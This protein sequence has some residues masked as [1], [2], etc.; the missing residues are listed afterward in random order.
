VNARWRWGLILVALAAVA[1]LR[2]GSRDPGGTHEVVEPTRSVARDASRA[3]PD[4][5]NEIL[6]LRP[7][8]AGSATKPLFAAQ[9]WAP[10]PAPPPKPLPPPPPPPPSAPALPFVFVGKRFDGVRWEVFANRGEHTVIFSEGATVENLYRVDTIR[11][12]QMVL[13]YL[14]LGERQTMNIGNTE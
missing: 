2:F 1:G 9:S 6:Q 4:D 10:P 3:R 14:P 11:P 12:P 7:R 13:T 8:T 5:G